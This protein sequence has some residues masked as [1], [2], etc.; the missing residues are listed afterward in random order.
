M[1]DHLE[2]AKLILP[3]RSTL[4]LLDPD[5]AKRYLDKHLPELDGPDLEYAMSFAGQRVNH[6]QQPKPQDPLFCAAMFL[7]GVSLGD[8]AMLFGIQRQTIQQKIARRLS[9]TERKELRD[10]LQAMDLE[11]L[12]LCKDT[13]DTALKSNPDA[14][15]GIHPIDI[16][17]ALISGANAIIARDRGEEPLTDRP[18][19]YSHAN[20][21]QPSGKEIAAD[22]VQK[23]P[24]TEAEKTMAAQLPLPYPDIHIAAS[25]EAVDEVLKD[26][27]PPSPNVVRPEEAEW[28]ENL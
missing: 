23:A 20:I 13:F 19:R 11:V 26:A 1:S 15:E 8:L 12:A 27:P 25:P 3:H 5:S 9:P 28:L 7:A 22:L 6:K 18:R 16:G 24:M 14:W 17:R 2:L 21:S 4:K 10:T